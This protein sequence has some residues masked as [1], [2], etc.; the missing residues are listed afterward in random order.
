MNRFTQTVFVV[1]LLVV[2]LTSVAQES[3]PAAAKPAA[4]TTAASSGN[5]PSEATL[6]A[7][8][9][10]MF[11]WNSDLS[12]KIVEIKPAEAAGLSQATV[13]FST[14]QGQQVIRF[15]VTADQKYTFSGELMPLAPT[16]SRALAPNCAT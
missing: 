7:F 6:T 9:K 1:T 3:K 13:L 14:P 10:Q 11:G 5:L 12:W 4:T 2:S 16:L 15:Y 8:L